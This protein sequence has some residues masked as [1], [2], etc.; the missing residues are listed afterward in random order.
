L[1]SGTFFVT[2]KDTFVA[3]DLKAGDTVLSV[4]A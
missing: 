4:S 1:G 3:F 2:D